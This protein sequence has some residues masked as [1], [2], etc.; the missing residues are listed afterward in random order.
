[1]VQ[2]GVYFENQ[3]NI[4]KRLGTDVLLPTLVFKA[5]IT[6]KLFCSMYLSKKRKTFHA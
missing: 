4:S 5:N 6:L 2:G 3:Q 1:M